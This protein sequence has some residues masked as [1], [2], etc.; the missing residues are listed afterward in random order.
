MEK[1]DVPERTIRVGVVCVLRCGHDHL[2]LEVTDP[3]SGG[4]FLIPSGGEVKFSELAAEAVIRAV[5]E[6]IGVTVDDPALLG[7]LESRIMFNNEPQ[8]EVMFCFG[9]DIDLA[10]KSAI[11]PE[12]IN[13]KGRSV[14]MRWL[15]RADLK[16]FDDIIVPSGLADLILT[17]IN[18]PKVPKPASVTGQETSAGTD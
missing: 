1:T 7:V 5:K 11:T 14:G 8:H 3:G 17:P 9:S 12:A 13:A 4:R 2:L 16:Q 15:N 10:T 18:D 6:D